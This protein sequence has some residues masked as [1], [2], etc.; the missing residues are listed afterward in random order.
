ML[1][2]VLCVATLAGADS[3]ASAE[4]ENS[5]TTGART[6]A[7]AAE[8]TGPAAALAFANHYRGELC[9]PDALYCYPEARGIPLADTVNIIQMTEN[10][11][12][13]EQLVRDFQRRF[14]T[15]PGA[16][17][18]RGI[19]VLLK[20]ERCATK[21]MRGC[22]VTTAA[23]EKRSTPLAADFLIYGC[24]LKPR[25]GDRPAGKL[26][27]ETGADAW[28]NDAAGLYGFQQG[29]G[30]TLVFLDPT[31]GSRLANSDALT[32]HLTEEDF[33]RNGGRTPE[34]NALMSE[35][36]ARLDRRNALR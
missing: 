6:A 13:H 23:L 16:A 7:S 30:A 4:V 21:V 29:P 25:D 22:T 28:K 27:I 11:W 33:A 9:V 34:L 14:A 12:T 36:L 31:N 5:A 18:K 32:L 17:R 20:T 2:A 35:V 24:L 1:A 10:L 8:N 26:K 15:V 3:R 19:I